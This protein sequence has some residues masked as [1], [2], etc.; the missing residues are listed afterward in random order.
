MKKISNEV[1]VGA[2]TLLTIVIFVWLFNFLK[3]KDLFRGTA[4][5]YTVYDKVGGL[6]ESSPVLNF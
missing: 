2:T 1:K 4:E 6:Q 3:G 5:Y